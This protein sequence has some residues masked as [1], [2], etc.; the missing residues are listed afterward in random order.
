VGGGIGGLDWGGWGGACLIEGGGV[1]TREEIGSESES[2]QISYQGAKEVGVNPLT[3]RLCTQP[4]RR[5]VSVSL[6]LITNPLMTNPRNLTRCCRSTLCCAVF[7]GLCSGKSAF[8]KVSH[9]IKIK[10]RSW[11]FWGY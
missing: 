1:E 11:C 4:P 8:V 9:Q 2:D 5:S 6:T 7:G 10:I 3:G